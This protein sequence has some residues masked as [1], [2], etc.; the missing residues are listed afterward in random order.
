VNVWRYRPGAAVSQDDDA[1]GRHGP[2]DRR[3][4][5]ELGGPWVN[6][7]LDLVVPAIVRFAPANARLGVP[8]PCPFPESQSTDSPTSDSKWRSFVAYLFVLANPDDDRGAAARLIND[9]AGASGVS[10][11]EIVGRLHTF[12]LADD[13]TQYLGDL[14]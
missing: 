12:V 6:L 4:E 5:F 9:F 7:R 13:L 1:V 11:A 2:D 3:H 8:M 14:S 10:P